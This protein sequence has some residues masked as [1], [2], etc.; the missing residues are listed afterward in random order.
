MGGGLGATSLYFLYLRKE[1]IMFEKEI[2]EITCENCG[3]KTSK[4]ISWLKSN[5]QLTCRCGTIINI[6]SSDLHKKIAV[7]EKRLKNLFK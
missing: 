1:L 2:I 4:T 7:V 6:D 3:A 5:K